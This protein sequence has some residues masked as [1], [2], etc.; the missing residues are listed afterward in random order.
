MKRIFTAL[1]F[2]VWTFGFAG[3]Q[4]TE[5][6][7][8]V[9]DERPEQYAFTNATIIVDY[10][11][12]LE[13]GTLLI[14]DG[15]IEAVGKDVKIPAGVVTTD[16][17]G[18]RIYPSLIDLYADYGMPEVKKAA[19]SFFGPPQLESKKKGP[20]YWNQAIHPETNAGDVFNADPKKAD[21]MRKIGFGT[22][23]THPPDG[24]IR[25]SSML[26]TLSNEKDNLTILNGK[27]S[28]HYSFEKG[29]STQDYPTSLMGAVFLLRQAYYDADWYRKAK[30]KTEYNASLEALNQLTGLPQ[31]MEVSDKLSVLRAD[32]VGDEFGV[33]Y[34]IKGA[35]NEYQRIGEIKATGA[36]LIVPVNFPAP[37][38][39]EDPLDASLVSLTEM[40]HWEL[41]PT[42]PAALANA[43]ISFSLTTAGLKT[44]AE[45][46][47]NLRKA[48]EHGLNER[49][50]LKA[51]TTT[52]ARLIK[53]DNLVGSLQKG[54]LANFLITSD[55]LFSP[56]N[57]IHENWIRGKKYVV[58]GNIKDAD[59]RGTYDLTVGSQ[60]VAK[61]RITG[62]ANAPEY[63]IAGS[64]TS[65]ITPK[66]T[67]SHDLLTMVF[68]PDKKKPQESIRLTGY[69][70]GKN[71]KGEGQTA[72]GTPVKWTA[73]F[74]EPFQAGVKKD[75][76]QKV[77]PQLGKVTYPFV[78]FG[79]EQKPATETLLIKNA[80]VW[81]NQKEGILSNTDVLLRDGKIA[82][83]GKNLN[84]AG[85][86]V[87]D[88]T[89][90]HLTNGIFDEHSHI[91][92]EAINEAAQS[93]TAE[94]R[95]E[96]VVDSEDIDIY[97][98]L[99]GG[100]TSSQLLHG[101]ANS[102]GG[103]SAL[104]KLKWGASPEEM[105]IKGADG[106]IKFALGENVKQS[107]R[108]PATALRFPQTRMG[109]EQ[110]FVDAFTRAKEY[111]KA[112]QAYN[113]R[114]DKN[115]AAAPRRDLELDAL[116]EILNRKRFI[117]C[118][119]YVQSEINMLLRVADS[120]GFKVNTFTH[121][122]EGYK[123]ADKM[124]AHGAGASTF[125][126]WW[127]YKMEVKDAVPYNAALMTGV[128]VTTAINSDDSEMARR[129]NQEAA[130]SVARGGLSEAEAWKMVTLN[131]AK[132]LHL[133]GRLGSI[134]PGKDAD[135]VLWT[136]NPLSIYAKAQTT[137]IEG[138][139]YYD[140]T[141]DQQ[142]RE[143]LRKERAR[144]I[145]KMLGAK[146]G[147]APTMKPVAKVKRILHCEEDHSGGR[148][149]EVR[150]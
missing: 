105:R 46:M 97:R 77:P 7:N 112:W 40:K 67:R 123:V 22:V 6:R 90:K 125:S 80:T 52:P 50:A 62:K 53:A 24:I 28:A 42:N 23:L 57:V 114:K 14:R 136:D 121:I 104:V 5:P 41:A 142:Q 30:D 87:I 78:A 13:G 19:F 108:N 107:S 8:G 134:Q 58:G 98:Q 102:I 101:S 118:H 89:G 29:S 47:A 103:Q 37:L 140:L 71:L 130:K 131:P 100:V 26:V 113:G 32:K 45:F 66:L 144:L 63:Q 59:I 35:G 33:Q 79:T 116:V 56:D 83:V 128:G 12:T 34:I 15:R 92:L 3:A 44:K 2:T 38:D 16:L 31:I 60:P 133:D 141:Q 147:G 145:G 39:V 54:M 117:T 143:V 99:S 25:G 96:D 115:K 135:V 55:N 122:L 124:K 61:L 17:K 51:L 64:D 138:A 76:A 95:M 91:A 106:F 72:D 4:T 75:S 49:E 68:A 127:A 1:I 94:V 148:E 109:V 111:E 139:V 48:I 70:E 36:P 150:W 126:D 43:G 69:V 93:V 82:Q 110:V 132:L 137:I 129:L 21:E 85:A 9:Y 119:S 88:G 73:T 81:T 20:Y 149:G 27:A 18:K 10:Q 65:K 146:A 120:L 86:R 84:A 74:R 11:T